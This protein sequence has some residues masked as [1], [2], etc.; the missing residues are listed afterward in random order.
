MSVFTRYDTVTRRRFSL[1]L[2][3]DCP[4][5]AIRAGMEEGLW[6]E[7]DFLELVTGR[8]VATQA[9]AGTFLLDVTNTV[10]N[11]VALADCNSTTSTQGINVQLSLA[12]AFKPQAGQD[13]WFEARIKA[14]DIA[15]GPEF[16]LGLAEQDTT[17]LASSVISTANHIGFLS[18]TDDNI[19]L[20][21]GEKA[22]TAATGAA[23]HTLVDDEYVK[24]GFKVTGLTKCEFWVDGV[25]QAE[26]FNL[27]TA[28]IPAVPLTLS[29]V[30]QSAGTTDPIVH[31]DW[32]DC[33]ARKY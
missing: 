7:D 18:V 31:I 25:Q 1:D 9:T 20:H 4:R 27:A 17:I 15:T 28:N 21:S 23:I 12:A 29:L 32:W 13:I 11:G 14:A 6:F 10:E 24:L 2:W 16:F 5:E 33:Y 3:K 19:V 22:G 26:T 8:Y 30:C